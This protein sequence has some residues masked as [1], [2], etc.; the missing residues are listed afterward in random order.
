M[1]RLA[2][3]RQLDDHTAPKAASPV[4]GGGITIMRVDEQRREKRKTGMVPVERDGETVMEEG[5]I[6]TAAVTVEAG[7]CFRIKRDVEGRDIVTVDLEDFSKKDRE[8][9][10]KAI[11][12]IE[13][14]AAS[15]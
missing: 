10:E 15:K 11:A 13:A 5:E 3:P 7:A 2:T 12:A 6:I 1:A 9:V 8:L 14:K 4:R